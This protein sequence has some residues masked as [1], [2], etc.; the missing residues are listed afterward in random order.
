MQK[1]RRTYRV[2]AEARWSPA[3]SVFSLCGHSGVYYPFWA[4]FSGLQ[5][6]EAWTSSPSRDPVRYCAHC[7]K[8][9]R[10]CCSLGE[11]AKSWLLHSLG[12]AIQLFI[13]NVLL[14]P[15]LDARRP[16]EHQLHLFLHPGHKAADLWACVSS[17]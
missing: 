14:F 12:V 2:A 9:V 1:G 4:A 11:T 6:R 17:P 8:R 3:S 15:L 5:F 10:L 13:L 7:P 16:Y